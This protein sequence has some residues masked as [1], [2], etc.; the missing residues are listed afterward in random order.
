MEQVEEEGLA[1]VAKVDRLPRKH[2]TSFQIA[3]LAQLPS[4]AAMPPS[5]PLAPPVA[6]FLVP[7][8]PTIFHSNVT[9]QCKSM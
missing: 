7:A 8:E 3:G 6:S 4:S 2:P 9:I 1:S 5:S